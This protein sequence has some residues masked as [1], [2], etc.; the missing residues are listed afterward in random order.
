MITPWDKT[1]LAIAVDT[2]DEDM[3]RLLLEAGEFVTLR[4]HSLRR[5]GAQRVG[6]AA[7]N[8]GI[9]GCLLIYCIN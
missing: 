6:E 8:T 3:A 7:A 4:W 5:C 2:G 1:P 9:A